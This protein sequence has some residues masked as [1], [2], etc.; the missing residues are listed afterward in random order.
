MKDLFEGKFDMRMY[1]IT[2]MY[3]SSIQKGIQGAHALSELIMK[4]NDSASMR[5]TSAIDEWMMRD[6]TIIVLNG[7]N[8]MSLLDLISRFETIPNCLFA[9][10][11]EDQDSLGG[12]LTAIAVLTPKNMDPELF[13]ILYL[14]D[15]AT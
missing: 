3:L 11:Y 12:A 15:L 10:F 14:L 7:G 5:A 1:F 6:K 2:N 9:P 13:N 8:W 4:I